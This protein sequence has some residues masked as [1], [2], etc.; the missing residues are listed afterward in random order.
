M[1]APIDRSTIQISDWPGLQTN[2]GPMAG[3]DPGGT[4]EQVNL[5]AIV[6][7]ELAA[8]PGIRRVLFDEED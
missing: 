7:G 3:A 1:A 8:R 5:R 4:V 2:T 6:V